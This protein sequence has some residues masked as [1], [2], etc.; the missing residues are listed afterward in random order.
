MPLIT[1]TIGPFEQSEDV[2]A[3]QK[4]ILLAGGFIPEEELFH[5]NV[6]GVFGGE[7]SVALINVLQ[8]FASPANIT[9]IFGFPF[10]AAWGRML[11]MAAAAERGNSAAL[12]AAVQ[13]S[14]DARNILPALSPPEKIW[15]ARFGVIARNFSVAKA[16][17]QSLAEPNDDIT[18]IVS[19]NGMQPANPELLNPENYYTFVYD[20]VSRA[21]VK[22]IMESNKV[23]GR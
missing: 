11:H 7:T 20:Y 18:R 21:D 2:T 5:D 1:R 13:E 15:M 12:Y 10:N 22:A 14:Y 17:N 6:N 23:R 8:R 4:D 16:I 3:I 9:N 19:Q